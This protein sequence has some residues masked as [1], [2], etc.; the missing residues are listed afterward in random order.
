MLHGAVSGPEVGGSTELQL[1]SV[2]YQDSSQC[3]V[4]HIGLLLLPDLAKRG[5]LRSVSQNRAICCVSD[6]K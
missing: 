3:L 1:G 5:E 4:L 6:K 2:F